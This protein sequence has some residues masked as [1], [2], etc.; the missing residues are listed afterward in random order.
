MD[1][2]FIPFNKQFIIYRPLC[3]LA[4]IGNMA[5]VRYIKEFAAGHYPFM[6]KKIDAFLKTI[7]FL[8][9]DPPPPKP[10]EPS[11]KHRPTM[12]VLLMTSDCNLRCT[13]C[14]ARGGE[15]S[16]LWMT[17]P[18]ARSVIDA[19]YENACLLKQE[20]FSLAFHGGGEPTLNWKVIAG[21]VKYAKQKKLPCNISMSTNGICSDR[22][23]EFIINHFNGLS[24]SF[25]GIREIQD[26]QRPR[27]DG[28][29]SFDAVMK[30][31]SALDKANSPYGIRLTVT[32]SSFTRLPESVAFL[33]QETQC[34]I[35]QVE[36]CYTDERGKYVDP[37]SEQTIAFSRKFLEGFEIAASSDRT[38][39]YSGARPWLITSSFCR[40]PEDALI[41]TPE[42]DVV[43]CFEIHDRRH[44]LIS[45]FVIGRASPE[46]VEIDMKKVRAFANRQK[47]LSVKCQGCFCYW[48][49]GGDCASRCLSS[50]EKNRSRCKVNRIITRELLAWYIAA[51]DGVWKINERF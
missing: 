19:A 11:D 15:D 41:V 36:P 43:T 37:T 25:D 23:R 17:L 7:G 6:D 39:F 26:I 48:H 44:S 12:A 42:G 9:P 14:Y 30:T 47:R 29:G 8:E 3:R 4:F 13:Y 35:M 49:C 18:L 10:W 34:K 50:Q 33:C 31:I 5:M 16:H 32:P 28:Q 21:A 38:L 40:A 22:Q 45:Q 1:I 27:H 2:H 24:I 20:Y 51:G 46:K